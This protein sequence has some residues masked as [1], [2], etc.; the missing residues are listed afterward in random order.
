MQTI[1]K[2]ELKVF[3]VLQINQLLEKL[4]NSFQDTDKKKNWKILK[5]IAYILD[6][7]DTFQSFY[8]PSL[9]EIAV[10]FLSSDQ[11][12]LIQSLKILNIVSKRTNFRIPY[13]KSLSLLSLLKDNSFHS[14]YKTLILRII[15][16]HID[17]EMSEEVVHEI[18]ETAKQLLIHENMSIQSLSLRLIRKLIQKYQFPI[19]NDEIKLYYSYANSKYPGIAIDGLKFFMAYAQN[20]NNIDQ[21]IEFNLVEQLLKISLFLNHKISQYAFYVFESIS[22]Q[23]EIGSKN[24]FENLTICNFFSYSFSIQTSILKI[25]FNFAKY[26]IINCLLQV[27]KE[28]FEFVTIFLES[29]IESCL[30]LSLNIIQI[31]QNSLV[32]LFNTEITDL[33]ESLAFHSNEQISCIS[34]SLLDFIHTSQ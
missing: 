28:A 5:I 11:N 2:I 7:K 13:E 16:H 19:S 24:V 17:I 14:D 21:I 22:G 20:K 18:Y 12:C 26:K 15:K 30:L 6:N 4:Q 25:I 1:L 27:S 34:K 8:N 33:L 32:S 9:S 23:G 29:D 3:P 10:C 31:L